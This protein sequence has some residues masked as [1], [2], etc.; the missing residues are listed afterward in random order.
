[1]SIESVL[2]DFCEMGL[3]GGAPDPLI[4]V[5]HSMARQAAAEIASLRADVEGLRAERD[6]RLTPEQVDQRDRIIADA[7]RTATLEEAARMCE[8]GMEF[9]GEGMPAI[10]ALNFSHAHARNMVRR[11][12]AAALRAMA[13]NEGE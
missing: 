1:M 9:A 13:G 6:E 7:A 8:A 5:M 2:L 11:T 4:E 10:Q 12:L 3:D